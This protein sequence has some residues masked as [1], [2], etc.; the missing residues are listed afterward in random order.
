MTKKK[1]SEKKEPD[2]ENE[3]E[4]LIRQNEDQASGMKKLIDSIN[5]NN[6]NEK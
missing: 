3:L 5:K 4:G 2:L 1:K 6:Q